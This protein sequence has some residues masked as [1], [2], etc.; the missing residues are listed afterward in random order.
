MIVPSRC[1]DGGLYTCDVFL[2]LSCNYDT[3]S[4]VSVH[5]TL[6]STRISCSHRGISSPVTTQLTH[7]RTPVSLSAESSE[8]MIRELLSIAAQSGS[9]LS[10]GVIQRS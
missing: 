9:K 5:E 7:L 3:N 10:K 2:W 1:Q 4:L 6:V 8:G